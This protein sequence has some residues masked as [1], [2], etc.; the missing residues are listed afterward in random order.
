MRDN[1]AKAAAP[2]TD[3]VKVAAS[4]ASFISSS[5]AVVGVMSVREN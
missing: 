3:V 2:T 5:L 1:S 4:A